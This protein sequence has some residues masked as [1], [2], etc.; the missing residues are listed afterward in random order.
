[1]MMTTTVMIMVVIVMMMMMMIIKM[2]TRLY[3]LPMF[4]MISRAECTV[5]NCME[6]VCFTLWLGAGIV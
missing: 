4:E 1:M 6:N 5:N 2:G 3:L